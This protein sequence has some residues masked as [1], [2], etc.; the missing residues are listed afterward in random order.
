VRP[1]GGGVSGSL[2]TVEP[3]LIACDFDGTITE[4]DTLHLIVAEYG[5]SDL[6]NRIEP[7]I[8]SGETSIEQA[9]QE[10]FAA[11][12][13]THDQVRDLV[14]REAGLRRGFPEFVRWA[15]ERD[16]RLIVFSSGFRS[17]ID[18]ILDHWGIEGLEVVSH[19][20]L[21]SADGCRLVWSDRGE[22]C[23]ECGRHC[24]RHDLRGR[25]RGE[26]LV[27]IGDGISD[28]CGARMADVVFARAQ[29]ADD[30]AADGVAFTRFEDFDLVRDRLDA[31]STLAA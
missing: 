5:S 4:R 31:L 22:L 8:L 21:F 11:V 1:A 17:V 20:A 3:L 25:S 15:R 12:R 18:E 26:R 16:H 30:L 19:E 29:L 9:M 27:Y 28:R 2:E 6:W 23:V 13:A 24:K 14:L 10:E 7:R